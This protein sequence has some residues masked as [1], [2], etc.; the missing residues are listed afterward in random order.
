M[1]SP[2]EADAD[3]PVTH[4]RQVRPQ[5]VIEIAGTKNGACDPTGRLAG[6][7]LS[8]A[9]FFQEQWRPLLPAHDHIHVLVPVPILHHYRLG[10]VKRGRYPGRAG[11]IG[12]KQRAELTIDPHII[13]CP[14]VGSATRTSHPCHRY[15]IQ[16]PHK[17]QVHQRSVNRAQHAQAAQRRDIH[18]QPIRPEFE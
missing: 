11:D 9:L 18:R 17:I 4:H 14:W 15:Q 2:I 1:L 3:F 10:V 6:N 5:I 13:G 12:E 7:Q 8:A 16:F